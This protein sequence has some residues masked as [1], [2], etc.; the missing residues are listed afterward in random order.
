M[1]LE[2]LPIN[3]TQMT[4]EIFAYG[5]NLD[6]ITDPTDKRLARIARERLE[7]LLFPPE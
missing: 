3:D 7:G 6:R 2:L 4:K 5:N 1:N